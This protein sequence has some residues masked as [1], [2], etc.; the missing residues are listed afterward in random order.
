MY[1][2]KSGSLTASMPGLP[3]GLPGPGFPAEPVPPPD[4]SLGA[5]E[6]PVGASEGAA[7]EPVLLA[8]DDVEELTGP[9]E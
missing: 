4:A 7:D 5:V 6:A 3:D 1:G 8:P 9:L 2:P